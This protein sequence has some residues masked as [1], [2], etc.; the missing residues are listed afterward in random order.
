[1]IRDTHTHTPQKGLLLRRDKRREG[2]TQAIFFVMV[3]MIIFKILQVN[4]VMKKTP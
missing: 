2:E 1:M 4:L 3:L